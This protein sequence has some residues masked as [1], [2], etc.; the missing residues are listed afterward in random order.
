MRGTQTDSKLIQVKQ[1]YTNY[2]T[3]LKHERTKQTFGHGTFS[4]IFLPRGG[5]FT[6]LSYKQFCGK[7]NKFS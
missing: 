7:V 2:L 6:K 4:K 5:V 1:F 3:T